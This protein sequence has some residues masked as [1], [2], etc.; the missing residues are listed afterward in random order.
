MTFDKVIVVR[1]HGGAEI[2]CK[3]IGKTVR[4]EWVWD[5]MLDEVLEDYL[6]KG[7]DEGHKIRI[8]YK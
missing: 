5:Y 4:T 3:H 6:K 8:V 7:D 2:T 1:K